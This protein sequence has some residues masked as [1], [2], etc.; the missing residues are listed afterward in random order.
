MEALDGI[1]QYLPYLIPI[2][3]LQLGLM[4]YCLYDLSRREKTKGPRW[5]WLVLIVFGELIGPV[6]YLLVGRIEE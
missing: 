5:L 2:L 1:S 6:L 3:L 4:A